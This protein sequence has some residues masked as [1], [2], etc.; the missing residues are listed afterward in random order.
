MLE[1]KIKAEKEEEGGAGVQKSSES[2]IYSGRLECKPRPHSKT[3][4][5][6][7]PVWE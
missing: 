3:R 6:S 2:E 7:G 4:R 5:V 1:G